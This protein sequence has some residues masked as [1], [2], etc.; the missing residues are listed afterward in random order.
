MM[1]ND[2]PLPPFGFL[3][4]PL[5]IDASDTMVT[6]RVVDAAVN[7][8]RPEQLS[9]FV[10]DLLQNRGVR[11][12]IGVTVHKAL[13]RLLKQSGKEGPSMVLREWVSLLASRMHTGGVP[14]HGSNTNATQKKT[15]TPKPFV[16]LCVFT[17]EKR[18]TSPSLAI[19]SI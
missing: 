18:E 3:L 14:L 5:M 8:I 7:S 11:R 9:K 2:E 6:M 16:C 13:L 17:K 12:C 4:S 19:N 15:H 10:K 1:L